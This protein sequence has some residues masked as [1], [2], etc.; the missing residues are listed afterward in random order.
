M[1][2][3]EHPFSETKL[4]AWVA[5]TAVSLP[6]P[7]TPNIAAAVK[8]RIQSQPAKPVWASRPWQRVAASALLLLLLLMAIPTAR[9]ALFSWLLIGNITL[10]TEYLPL[11]VTPVS[12]GELPGKTTLAEVKTA[13]S[14]DIPI[15]STLGEPSDVYLLGDS[16]LLLWADDGILLQILDFNLLGSKLQVIS[17]EA[18]LVGGETA[19]WVTG[20]HFLTLYDQQFGGMQ[21]M[22]RRIDGNVLIWVEDD[23]TYRLESQLALTDAVKLAETIKEE[24]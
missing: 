16:V 9:A 3:H 5:E 6:Y 7:P 18:V 1:N 13:V 11:D 8:Q 17:A 4:A 12:L 10:S 23:R 15:P 14:F 24:K 20:D 21:Q 19:V 2:E 22:T